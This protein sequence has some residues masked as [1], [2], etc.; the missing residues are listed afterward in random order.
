MARY[1]LRHAIAD[2]GS[3]LNGQSLRDLPISA[4]IHPNSY[5]LMSASLLAFSTFGILHEKKLPCKEIFLLDVELCKILSF[6]VGKGRRLSARK[7]R[8]AAR[9]LEADSHC[10]IAC[11][12]ALPRKDVAGSRLGGANQPSDQR[13][14]HAERFPARD[15]ALASRQGSAIRRGDRMNSPRQP[16]HSPS[17]VPAAIAATLH[18][19]SSRKLGGSVC[20]P[21]RLFYLSADRAFVDL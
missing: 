9:V 19:V 18:G 11:Y 3:R 17:Y 10:A 21:T 1:P 7:P 5:A 4:A 16:R 2:P 12:E 8:V 6:T 14:G 15:S 20:M 13:R